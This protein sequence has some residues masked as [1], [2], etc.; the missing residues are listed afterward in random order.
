MR[1]LW[2]KTELLHPV[3]KGGRIRSYQL[4]RQ[5]KRAREHRVI[6]ACLDDGRDPA[7]VAAAAEYCDQL[8][9]VPARVP[10]KGTPRYWLEVARSLAGKVP[11]AVGRYRSEALAA[12]V[13]RLAWHADVVVCDFLAAA[14]SIPDGLPAPVVLFEHNIETVI[15]RRRAQWAAD[16]VRRRLL[17]REAGRVEAFERAQCSRFAAVVAVSHGD[18]LAARRMGAARTAVVPTGV[19][20]EFFSPR[21]HVSREPGEILFLGSMD[22]S[23]NQDAVIWF[24]SQ[25]WPRVRWAH[26]G[27]RFTVVGRRPSPR[28][29]A[30]ADIAG[31]EVIADVADVRPF[32]A[33]AACVVV[34]LRVGGGTRLKIFEALA[35]DCPVVSTR[36]GAEGLPLRHGEELL[37][38]DGSGALARAVTAVLRDPE[39]AAALG[40]RAGERVRARFGWER[41]AE[42]FLDACRDTTVRLRWHA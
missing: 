23:P 28:V 19:D 13:R 14:P 16:P 8:V 9:R 17:D 39:R 27:A 21:P 25:I 41:A 26:P 15:W 1:F 30:L 18:A 24:A 6:Y 40:R 37:L 7:A 2:V 29:R 4:L 10:R 31:V 38:A 34:P 20:V 32:L 22:W 35:M 12:E 11:Y 33:R 36:V 3:D 42:A 5:L